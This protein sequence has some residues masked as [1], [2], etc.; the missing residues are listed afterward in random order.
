MQKAAL[1][2]AADLVGMVPVA[3]FGCECSDGSS[4]TLAC[5]VPPRCAVNSVRY[6][7]VTTT[8]IYVPLFPYP[9]IPAALVLKGSSR[10]R[11]G[12]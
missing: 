2:D 12:N 6:V 11:A 8:A 4:A 10:M 3:T 9:G 1:L 7:E 5:V